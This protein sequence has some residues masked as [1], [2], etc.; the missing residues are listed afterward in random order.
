LQH[1]RKRERALMNKTL[2]VHAALIAL[3][4]ACA[5]GPDFIRPKA[6]EVTRLTDGELPPQTASADNKAGAAQVFAQHKTLPADWWKLFN[7]APL[8]AL[9]EQALAN[10]PDLQAAKAS[11]TQAQESLLSGRGA[12][13]PS[14]GA[15]FSPSR[16]RT[17]PASFGQTGA[18]SVFNLYNASV[19]VSYAVD[20]FGATQRGVEALEAQVDFQRYELEAAYLTLTANVAN[21]AIYEAS[22]REQIEETR[23]IIAIQREQLDLLGKQFELGAIAKT[24]VLEQQALV[25]QTETALPPLQKQLAQQ[26]NLLALLAGRFP[27]EGIEQTFD[28]GALRLP[29]ELPVS[30]PSDL[31]RQRP[32]IRASEALLKAANAEVGLA[33]AAMLPRITL[34]GSYGGSAQAFDAVFTPD[35]LVWSLGANIFQPLFRGGELLH[36]KRSKVAAYEKANAQYR[37][38]VLRAFQNVA[39]VLRALQYDADALASQVHAERAAADSFALSQSQYKVGAITYSQMLDT[40]RVWQ[41]ARIGLV[42]AQAARYADTVALFQALG[43]GWWNRDA[44]PATP[45]VRAIAPDASSPSFIALP[46]AS[47]PVNTAIKPQP[48]TPP[49][50]NP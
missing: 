7:S 36:A 42:Q 18:G 27:A 10:N 26:R 35:T 43:G 31:V 41:Q 11:L 29:E 28:L 13:L 6:P 45:V 3:T 46:P 40:Q 4:S 48:L 17:S 1:N 47:V 33:T 16:Q 44:K 15:N 23:D 39:D 38:T 8:N 2:L 50:S 20:V 19:D 9:M 37:S 32:D 21:A 30:L 49:E 34:A 5:A 14:L 24:A 25:A 22:L 12:L